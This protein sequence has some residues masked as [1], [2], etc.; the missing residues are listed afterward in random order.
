MSICAY[1]HSFV[2]KSEYYCFLIEIMDELF[3]YDVSIFEFGQLGINTPIG[4]F[5][6]QFVQNPEIKSIVEVG[7]WNGRGSTRSIMEGLLKREDATNFYSLEAE[8]HR[9]QSGVRFWETRDKGNVNLNL[10][11]GK[12]SNNMV[13]RDYVRLHPKF[14]DQLQYYDFELTQTYE[15]PLVG[16][17]LPENVEFVFLDGG[18]FC[19]V[20]DYNF[21]VKKYEHSLKFIGLDDIDTIKNEEIYKNLVQPDSP[22]KLIASGP[23]PNRV[24]NS[25]GNT[26]AFFEKK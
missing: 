18:E 22:W 14:S 6:S 24:G 11:W 8:Q 15:A 20:Y 2:K 9:Q 3:R 13:S 26:W 7:T 19:S 16:D 25:E 5:L 23:H 17:D 12:L 1:R 4:Q 21:L 10:L